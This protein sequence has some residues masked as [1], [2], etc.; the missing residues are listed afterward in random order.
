MPQ[1]PLDE[2]T[3]VA[4]CCA[5]LRATSALVNQTSLLGCAWRA[6]FLRDS[7]DV[8]AIIAAMVKV[9]RSAAAASDALF[10]EVCVHAQCL[11]NQSM[12]SGH[13]ARQCVSGA[14][15]PWPAALLCCCA[16][17]RGRPFRMAH[18]CWGTFTQDELALAIERQSRGQ[19]AGGDATIKPLL[20]GLLLKPPAPV[21]HFGLAPEEHYSRKQKEWIRM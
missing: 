20:T 17:A 19:G 8:T 7:S 12:T 6:A 2:P 3:L 16:G 15:T 10:P 1:G 13:G 21:I 11:C 4:L 18:D 14:C 9:P 5:H